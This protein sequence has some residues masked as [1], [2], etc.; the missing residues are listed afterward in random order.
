MIA[1]RETQP[2]WS[3]GPLGHRM[4]TALLMALLL[5][6]LYA[7]VHAAAAAIID[8]PAGYMSAGGFVVAL[9]CLLFALSAPT[10]RAAWTRLSLVG[11]AIAFALGTVALAA[12]TWSDGSVTSLPIEIPW[13]LQATW[14][15]VIRGSV[16]AIVIVSLGLTLLIVAYALHRRR[17]PADAP[18][19][20]R[21]ARK[22]PR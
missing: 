11:G 2:D 10:L 4:M 3:I 12:A 15:S 5:L 14:G 8:V 6:L 7:L 9:G 18:H 20:Y 16:I 19:R 22:L 1:R 17:A 13:S 21:H